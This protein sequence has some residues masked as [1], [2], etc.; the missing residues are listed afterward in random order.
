VSWLSGFSYRKS[1]PI[2]AQGSIAGTVAV[3]NGS[4]AVVGTSTLFLQ[5][6]IGHQIKLPDNNWYTI[7][8]ITDDTHLTIS[9]VYPGSNASGQTYDMRLVNYQKKLLVGESSNSG[10]NDV[11][12]EGHVLPTFN[13]LRFTNSDGST[14]LDY[15]IESVSGTTPNQVATVWIEFDF[16]GTV[17]TT[18][19]MYYG[20][21][22][23]YP[24]DAPTNAN[25]Q[26]Y[27]SNPVLP[28]GAA[29]QWDDL[30]CVIWSIV[31][32]GSTW[33]G[34]YNGRRS[35]TDMKIGLATSTDDGLTWTK[36][37]SWTNPIL[38]VGAGGQ[39]DETS[40]GSPCVWKEGS[41]WYMLYNGKNAAGT[42]AI[43]LATSSDGI[44]WTK[45]TVHNP[46][47]ACDAGQW[48]SG[49]ISPGTRM[50]KEG[51]TYYLYYCGSTS[52]G[53]VLAN[54]KIGLATSTNLTSWS[55]SGNNP[56]I[57]PTGSGLDQGSDAPSIC[58]LGSTYYIFYQSDDGGLNSWIFLAS[59]SA[60]DSGWTKYANNPIFNHGAAGQWDSVWTESPVLVLTPGNEW[61]IYYCGCKDTPVQT[62]FIKYV[63]MGNGV[64]TFLL[65]DHFNDGAIGAIWATNGTPTESVTALVLDAANKGIKSV[66][67]YGYKRFRASIQ[68]LS[69]ASGGRNWAGF[70]NVFDQSDVQ[71]AE[72]VPVG[73]ATTSMYDQV[74]LTGYGSTNEGTGFVDK[75]VTYQIDRLGVG[76]VKFYFDDVA[77]NA[78]TT[79]IPTAL[80]SAWFFAGISDNYK[81]PMSVDWVFIANLAP[82]EP[83][84]GSWGSEAVPGVTVDVG[85]QSG[86][87]TLFSVSEN[88]DQVLGQ[89]LITK[90]GS[91]LSPSFVLDQILSVNLLENIVLSS[92][93]STFN[94]GDFTALNAFFWPSLDLSPY[95]GTDLGST[96]YRIELIDGTGKKATGYIGAVGAG[97]TLDVEKII[98]GTFDADTDWGKGTGWSIAT[99]KATTLNSPH[100]ENLYPSVGVTFVTNGLYKHVFTLKDYVSGGLTI[101]LIWGTSGICGVMYHE[102]ITDTAY[103]TPLSTSP[104]QHTYQANA[105]YWGDTDYSLDN[106]SVKRV[107]DPP[108]TAVHIVSSLNGTT[109]NWASIESGFDPNTIA[110]WNIKLVGASLFSPSFILDQVLTQ[111]LQAGAGSAFSS[112]SQ[113]D[114]ILTQSLLE[115]IAELLSTLISTDQVL[116]VNIESGSGSPYDV[117]VELGQGVTIS[118][119][120]LLAIASMLG[121]SFNT[122]QILDQGLISGSKTLFSPSLTLDQVLNQNLISGNKTIFGV[123]ENTDQ[124]LDQNLLESIASVLSVLLSTDQVLSVNVTPGA[125]SLYDVTVE[126]IAGEV[127]VT[128]SLGLLLGMYSVLSTS[129]QTDQVLTQNLQSALVTLHQILVGI[130]APGKPLENFRYQFLRLKPVEPIEE[131]AFS[132]EHSSLK[133]PDWGPEGSFAYQRVRLKKVTEES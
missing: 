83:A 6:G 105:V 70:K 56:L 24:V 31:I 41:N 131:G 104:S 9:I 52:A 38:D 88:T 89:G 119:T 122:D 25:W 94:R 22:S 96:P 124:I 129:L 110:S 10:T 42:I 54:R 5:W 62:G 69:Q 121:I 59:S 39:W 79:Q 2:T 44:T 75:F 112:L 8:T 87:K 86:S 55:K 65:F 93:G 33:Y 66:T 109:R 28:V 108:S 34:Y 82:A 120:L 85:L 111:N 114:Q 125:G 53:P 21:S 23:V 123:S 1:Q 90:A 91:L 49:F 17:A 32:V 20:G 40:V 116:S 67:T 127:S 19:Y 12:C 126:I 68:F 7:A 100:G 106:I 61:R 80:L 3:T 4:A 64:N 60:K 98:N 72:V 130:T 115:S 133:A 132:Y 113:T 51:S 58:Y 117:T 81:Q 92:L 36:N 74:Y 76:S 97:E 30:W 46:V 27:G 84:W 128:V 14:L 45:D 50:L 57:S 48:D 71:A 63:S 77:K 11:H 18:F 73:G 35:A 107:T 103:F 95:A 78:Y 37:I 15:W 29:G 43:G 13:D 102:N 118:L 47:M 16:L 26:R 99:G 101:Y